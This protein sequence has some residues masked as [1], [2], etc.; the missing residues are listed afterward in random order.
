MLSVKDVNTF[1][2]FLAD[3]SSLL[4]AFYPF[5]NI[6]FRGFLLMAQQIVEM[7]ISELKITNPYS[8]TDTDVTE[9]EKSIEQAGL[10]N[11]IV[12]N[13]EKI[14]LAGARRLQAYKNLGFDTIPVLINNRGP[15]EQ[16]LL[17]I[18]ENL[19]R[20]DLTKVE[21]EAQ[22]RRAKEIY[23]QL[24]PNEDAELEAIKAVEAQSDESSEETK[25][26]ILPA[27]KFLDHVAEKT[28]LSPRQIHEAISRDE[29]S[30]DNVKHLRKNGELSISQTNEIVKL[31]KESQDSAIHHL[32][33]LPVREIKNFIKV[34][35]AKGV[36][37]AIKETRP[38]PHAREFNEVEKMLK[39]LN[40]MLKQ[41]ELEGIS[42]HDFPATTRRSFEDLHNIYQ[43]IDSST[44]Y[45]DSHEDEESMSLN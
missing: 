39:R 14:V 45:N 13:E 26:E 4:S 34:S 43:N 1:K 19:V 27:Q 35:K 38:L 5:T 28:G 44:S 29:K 6:F 9:L 25:K 21:L 31:D 8:R 40:K 37:V 32:K 16:E 30:S 36:E 10:I 24:N 15:L 11:P 7:S 23:Q 18:D 20:K 22:L 2:D 42:I 41:L 33:S 3:Y 17:S 12:I